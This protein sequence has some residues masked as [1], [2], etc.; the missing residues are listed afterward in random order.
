MTKKQSRRIL[1]AVVVALL[2][3]VA[4]SPPVFAREQ[5][6][7]HAGEAGRPRPQHPHANAVPPSDGL[8]VVGRDA[9]GQPMV[10][11]AP[12]QPGSV[13][14]FGRSP[15][16]RIGSPGIGV[17]GLASSAAARQMP[18]PGASRPGAIVN[19]GTIGG[20][21][22]SRRGT[23]LSVLGGPSVPSGGINGT[24]FPARR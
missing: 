8:G 10:P 14:P 22:L 9:L 17:G 5:P 6:R 3:G 13:T 12:V 19:R 2:P 16:Q 18:M 11:R 15:T 20:S 21:S 7:H 23:T 1:L 24:T 4:A